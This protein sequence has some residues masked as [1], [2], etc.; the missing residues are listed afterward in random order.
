[1]VN[2][3]VGNLPFSATE[4]DL[5]ALFAPFGQIAKTAL[6]LDRETGR[7]RGFGFVEMPDRDEALKAIEAL[8]GSDVNGRNLTINEARPR[9]SG[10]T[11][12][13]SGGGFNEQRSDRGEARGFNPDQRPRYNERPRYGTQGSAGGSGGSG[14]GGGGSYGSQ[15]SSPA[16]VTG[17]RGYGNPRIKPAGEAG[18]E[19]P[20]GG[21]GGYRN[22]HIE[23]PS[24]DEAPK[25]SG[26]GNSQADQ[27]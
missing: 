25:A 19:T 4:Q 20:N 6:I 12:G 9:G 8:N 27:D 1:M 23:T 24:D 15:G 11:G 18:S 14:S 5:H 2:I 13:G 10:T 17:S 3:Y 7:S 26:Y 22:K 16:S 21:A